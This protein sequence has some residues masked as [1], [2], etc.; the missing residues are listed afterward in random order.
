MSDNTQRG[1][2]EIMYQYAF[3]EQSLS[4]QEAKEIL[5]A[6]AYIRTVSEVLTRCFKVEQLELQKVVT[7]KLCETIGTKANRDSI[8]HKVRGWLT[9]KKTSI[10]KESAVHLAFALK[11]KVSDAEELLCRLSGE[12]F[13]WRDPGDIVLMF[14]LKRKMLYCDALALLDRMRPLYEAVSSTEE[15]SNVMTE[16]IKPK[17]EQIQ[18]EEDLKNFFIEEAPKLGKMHNYAYSMYKD[19]IS[20]LSDDGDMVVSGEKRKK[21]YDDDDDTIIEETQIASNILNVYL[22][23]NAVPVIPKKSRILHDAIQRD[24][25]QNWPDK[26]TLSRM[27]KRKIDITRKVL[28]LLFLACDGGEAAY[29]NFDDESDEDIFH[30]TYR[31]LS[32]MLS[33]CGFPLLD[34][35]NPFDWMV[36]Y[37]IASARD[38]VDIDQNIEDFL[39]AIFGT[40]TSE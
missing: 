25:K 27:N 2:T 40:D 21:K 31:R 26:Y 15:D 28:I 30:D 4:L 14:A 9:G 3:Q 16:T 33:D 35:R 1:M 11:L 17:I 8:A 38:I 22:H 13:H 12:K 19:F 6:E 10:N 29:G 20:L 7:D 23:R 24:I 5:R 36:L 37:C 39:S 18:T 32:K 34:A